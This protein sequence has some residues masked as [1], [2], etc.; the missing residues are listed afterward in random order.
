V[1]GAVGAAGAAGGPAALELLWGG[2]VSFFVLPVSSHGE[3]STGST[4]IGDVMACCPDGVALARAATAVDAGEV[5]AGAA[6][7]A[8]ASVAGAAAGDSHSS[9]SGTPAKRGRGDINGDIQ[10]T[11]ESVP[12]D[13]LNMTSV[14]RPDTAFETLLALKSNVPAD[15]NT[16]DC[17][18]DAAEE[19]A[20]A[21]GDSHCSSS[22]TPAKRGRGDING[23]MQATSE[24]VPKDLLNMTSVTRPDTAFETLLALKSNVPADLNTGDASRCAGDAAVAT[25]GA[26]TGAAGA[27][28]DSHSSSS[29]T[30]AKRGR[31]DINGDMQATSESVPKDLLNMTSVTRPDTA[32]ET[33]LALKSNEPADLNTGDAS[34]CAGETVVAPTDTATAEAAADTGAAGAAGDSHS[35]SSGTP[36]KRG[37]GDINGD[38]H[39]TSESVP[40]DLLNMTSVTRPDTAFEALLALKLNVLPE[41]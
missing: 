33:L 41:L 34:R 10:A 23:D 27:A 22:G 11:S 8:G 5:A 18:G 37:R 14:T 16:G 30:P 36:A 3:A 38:M 19:I 40:K 21:A 15:L 25:A 31:G 32:F 13:L 39:A 26:G 1:V 2:M 4:W 35:S 17:A 20:G 6:A 12:K 24:S 7:G 28:G 29:G 9:S